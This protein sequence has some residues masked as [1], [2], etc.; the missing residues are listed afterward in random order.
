MAGYDY[1]KAGRGRPLKTPRSHHTSGQANPGL[2]LRNSERGGTLN[3]N[4]KLSDAQV[5]MLREYRAGGWSHADLALLFGISESRSSEICRGLGYKGA[6]G[7]IAGTKEKW[8]CSSVTAHREKLNPAMAATIKGLHGDG[9]T[10]GEIARRIYD[11]MG[12]E[13]SKSLVGL[14]LRG[15]TKY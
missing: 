15:H 8:Y 4:A 11:D 12:V 10:H 3:P 14:C 2:A 7:P 5:V 6:G 9:L 13:I 1:T